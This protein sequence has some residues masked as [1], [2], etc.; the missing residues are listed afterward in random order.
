[1]N[2]KGAPRVDFHEGGAR[3][4]AD[5]L[6][7][8]LSLTVKAV[9]DGQRVL[10]LA[11]DAAQARVLD[12]R[13]WAVEGGTFI[14]HA[15]ADDPDRD[16][17]TVVVAAPDHDVEARSLVINLRS[18]VVDIACP[19]IIELIPADEDGKGVARDR[20]RAYQARGIKPGKIGPDA[21]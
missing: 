13:L 14:A 2:V 18:G 10:I 16:A 7:Q 1:M 15:L 3:Y 5:P 8:V 12:E 9:E 17:A 21:S 20:W 19:R 6:A 4:A 11:V